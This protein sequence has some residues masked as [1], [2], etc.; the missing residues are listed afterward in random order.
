MDAAAPPRRVRRHARARAGQ[1]VRP[2]ARVAA[3]L[4]PA[5]LLDLRGRGRSSRRSATTPTGS[6]CCATSAA[7]ATRTR[8]RPCSAT[9]SRSAPGRSSTTPPTRPRSWATSW[10]SRP[11]GAPTRS[12]TRSSACC[13]RPRTSGRSTTSPRD[14]RWPTCSSQRLDFGPGV[15]EALACTFERWN[16]KGFPAHAEGEAIPLAMRVVHLSHD[17][18]AIG[19]I[20][21]P[22][23]AL[24][25]A[26]DRRGRTYDPAL[27][28]LFVEHGRAWF[29]RLAR[30]RAVGR[31]A[32]PRA[33]TPSGAGRGG[34]RPGADRRRRLHR[35]E[36]AVHGRP[37]P[38]LRG[39]R[40]R[41]RAGPRAAGGG[42]RRAAPGGARA[43][44][45]R[46]R[47]LELDLGQAGP[48]HADGV[49]P[50]RAPPDADRA[51]APPLTGA[52]RPQPGGVE[53]TTRSATAPATTRAR[54]PTR[55]TRRHASWPR[56][57]STWG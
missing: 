36:V 25:A 1:R 43:R 17:M 23:R 2:A 47:G 20:F 26:Q 27:A 39:A 21:S 34:A 9:R 57:R 51:D 15:R 48:A 12:A 40:D 13:R 54:G 50:R 56:R 52:R 38:P 19:R 41:R 22:E 5:R 8:S 28:D 16:G 31:R 42:G 6:R 55:A 3:A 29:E 18:E 46:H 14:A 49:R 30:A 24:E 45:R 44:L 10:S 53:P 33:R 37:Q 7:P 4:V 35:H 11:P 32:R